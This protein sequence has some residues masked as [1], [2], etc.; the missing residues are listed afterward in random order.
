M[1]RGGDGRD[2]EPTGCPAAAAVAE[3]FLVG[4]IDERAHEPA[5]DRC[6]HLLPPGPARPVRGEIGRNARLAD[7]RA[8]GLR[9]EPAERDAPVTAEAVPRAGDEETQ[10]VL[11]GGV[12]APGIHALPPRRSVLSPRHALRDPRLA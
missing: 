4:G 11:R 12:R 2:G 10:L 6:D 1:K 3:G 8:A 7:D 9:Q 5:R